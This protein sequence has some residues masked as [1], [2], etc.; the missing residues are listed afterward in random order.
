LFDQVIVKGHGRWGFRD[1]KTRYWHPAVDIDCKVK[2]G[3]DTSTHRQKLLVRDY[4]LKDNCDV[5]HRVFDSFFPDADPNLVVDLNENP[6]G[7]NIVATGI[8]IDDD[9]IEKALTKCAVYETAKELKD[10]VDETASPMTAQQTPY[11]QQRRPETRGSP[12]L[13]LW[14]STAF[15]NRRVT[16]GRTKEKHS[17]LTNTTQLSANG[18]PHKLSR[19]RPADRVSEL[20]RA[21]VLGGCSLAGA[22]GARHSLATACS[23]RVSGSFVSLEAAT[24]GGR[25]R[26]QMKTCAHNS[27]PTRGRGEQRESAVAHSRSRW[28]S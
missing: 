2:E 10:E 21:G 4:V 27:T 5:V 19:P 26:G 20:G 11:R 13:L 6:M 7:A 3:Q 16:V 22:G 14:S 9:N 8:D 18:L 15:T 25:K 17:G 24:S 28:L 23:V 1:N 12:S